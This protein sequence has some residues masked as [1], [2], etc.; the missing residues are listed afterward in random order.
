MWGFEVW[1]E[2]VLLLLLLDCHM[3]HIHRE[4]GV[5]DEQIFTP[6]PGDGAGGDAV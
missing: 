2:E 3:I 1:W 6:L 4:F 5:H